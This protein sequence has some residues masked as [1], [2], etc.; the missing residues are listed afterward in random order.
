FFFCCHLLRQYVCPGPTQAVSQFRSQLPVGHSPD[1]VRAEIFTHVSPP[2][3][4]RRS[5]LFTDLYS[6]FWVRIISQTNIVGQFDLH[7]K[8]MLTWRKVC[9]FHRQVYILF[10]GVI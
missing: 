9:H 4:I 10:I 8:L 2:S 7:W 6:H 3:N 5:W 1:A